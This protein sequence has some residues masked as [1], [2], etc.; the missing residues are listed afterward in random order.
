[1]KREPDPRAGVS[2]D[3]ADWVTQTEAL[4]GPGPVLR[5]VKK[6]Q[7]YAAREDWEHCKNSVTAS[8]FMLQGACNA[9][10]HRFRDAGLDPEKVKEAMA[11]WA[12]LYE[13]AI[14]CMHNLDNLPDDLRRWRGDSAE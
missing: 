1:M 13:R 14:I 4:L 2:N 11:A 8:L 10:E 5:E 12:K 3:V 7:V 6:V 9:A